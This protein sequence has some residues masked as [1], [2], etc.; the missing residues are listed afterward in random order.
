VTRTASRQLNILVALLLALLLIACDTPAATP[1]L[2][3][4]PPSATAVPVAATPTGATTSA[5]ATALPIVTASPELQARPTLPITATVPITGTPNALA[6]QAP[7][8]ARDSVIYQVFVRNFTPEGTLKAAQARLHDLKDLGVS[9]IY[10]MPIHPIGQVHRKGSLGSPYSIS[11]YTQIDPAY[12][13]EADFKAFVDAAHSLGMRVMLDLVANHTAWDNVLVTQHPDWY[14]HDANGQFVPPQ[15]EWTDVIQLDHSRPGVLQYF[16]D[17]TTHYMQADGVDGWRCDYSTGP[18]SAFWQA[19]RAAVKQ[20]NPDV[21]LL[22]ENDEGT[23][24]QIWS[25]FDATYDQTTYH[26]IT[27]AFL[28]HRPHR[29]IVSPLA[30]WRDY[31]PHRLR[32]RFFENHDQPRIALPFSQ[33]PPEALRAASTYLLTAEGIPFIENGQEVGITHTMSL[34]EPDPIPWDMGDPALRDHFKKIL[35]IRNSHPALRHGDIAEGNSSVP[36][37]VAFVR[38]SEEQQV[39]VLVSL[40]ATAQHVTVDPALAARPGTDLETGTA[41][42]LSGGLDMPAYSWRI[43]E[44]RR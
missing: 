4:P 20:V 35:A 18:P 24:P 7:A 44:L 9:L 41:V 33:A 22:S 8:W 14:K 19:W 36:G 6:P 3:P 26:D 23:A 39:L 38:R 42:P 11:D 25:A 15:P 2:P 27:A 40:A 34:F 43:I 30:D 31:G 10:L 29:L 32:A 5:T 1:T 13:T 16:V 37:V 21:F 12:G 28:S 17:M